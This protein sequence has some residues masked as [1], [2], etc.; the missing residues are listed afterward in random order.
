M[1]RRRQSSGTLRL[2][3]LLFFYLEDLFV[4]VKWQRFGLENQ[5]WIG[6]QQEAITFSY[7]LSVQQ[8]ALN[9]LKCA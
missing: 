9:L 7:Q 1:S 2:Y 3:A 8:I 4:S 6:T 5:I